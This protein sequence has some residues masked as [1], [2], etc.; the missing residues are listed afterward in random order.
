[1]L[2]AS[3]SLDH[4]TSVRYCSK[5]MD[6]LL[7]TFYRVCCHGR[8]P[9]SFAIRFS[10]RQRQQKLRQITTMSAFCEDDESIT[11]YP[12]GIFGRRRPED[13]PLI[14]CLQWGDNVQDSERDTTFQ[15]AKELTNTASKD[16]LRVVFMLNCTGKT[17]PPDVQE[18]K[19]LFKYYSVPS[20]MLT[21]RMRSVN[22]SFGSSQAIESKAQIS[23]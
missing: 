17:S 11:K 21:D 1:M 5:R 10:S 12:Q 16:R 20:D 6:H 4:L 15:S 13:S 3:R 14:R 8:C 7:I 9:G 22:H 23:W 18:F 19:K 2:N